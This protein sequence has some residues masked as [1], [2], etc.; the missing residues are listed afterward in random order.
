MDG[1]FGLLGLLQDEPLTFVLLAISLIGALS[2][3]EYAHAL[4]A[5]LQGDRLPRAMGRLTINPVKH[6]D[7]LGTICIFLV[8]FGW[9]KPVEFRPQALRSKRFGAAIVALAGPLMNLF[10]GLLAAFAFVPLTRDLLP[11]SSVADLNAL[12]LF[13]FLFLGLNVLLAVFNLFPLPPLDGSR[14]LTIFLP[15]RHQKIVFFLDR[16]GFLIL[17]ALVF[18][19]GARLLEPVTGGVLDVMLDIAGR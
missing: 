12:Q 19:G 15:P 1:G 8:G 16:Y 14:L 11:G 5:D 9:G 17:L 7:P 2:L 3:H 10:L 4:A 18:F 13:L 6:L